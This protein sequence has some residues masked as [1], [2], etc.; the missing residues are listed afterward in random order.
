MERAAHNLRGEIG[1]EKV[2]VLKSNGP[3]IIIEVIFEGIKCW[4]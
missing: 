2:L 4:S 1:R 3:L